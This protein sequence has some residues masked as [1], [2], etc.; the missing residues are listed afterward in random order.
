MHL[1][2]NKVAIADYRETAEKS[3]YGK[4]IDFAFQIDGADYELTFDELMAALQ[5]FAKG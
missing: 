3:G 4:I 2:A 5:P 1:V